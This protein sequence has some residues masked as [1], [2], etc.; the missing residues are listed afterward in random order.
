MGFERKRKEL[1]I[2]SPDFKY[3]VKLLFVTYMAWKFPDGYEYQEVCYYCKAHEKTYVIGHTGKDFICSEFDL[4]DI[5][6]ESVNN[7]VAIGSGEEI[8]VNDLD[9]MFNDWKEYCKK[10]KPV[11]EDTLAELG[12]IIPELEPYL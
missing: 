8:T 5:D 2:F 3:K 7:I 1:E 9:L 10:L 12:E 6:K 11:N 4:N